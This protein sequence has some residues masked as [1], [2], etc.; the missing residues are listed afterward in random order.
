MLTN[1]AAKLIYHAG[2]TAV[3]THAEPAFVQA[4]VLTL[5]TLHALLHLVFS[6]AYR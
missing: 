3:I 6:S 2:D 1:P 4:I 5:T